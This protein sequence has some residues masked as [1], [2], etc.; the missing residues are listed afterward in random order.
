MSD[1]KLDED[2]IRGLFAATPVYKDAEAFKARVTRGLRLK[3]WLRQGVIVLAGVI[4]G[5]YALAQFVR[6]PNW[7]FGEKVLSSSKMAR[8]ETDQTFRAG[9]EFF[10]VIGKNAVNLFYSSLHYLGIMQ[11]PVFFWVSFSLCLACLALY[12]AYSQE[13]TI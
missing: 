1:M 12:Y 5:L 10:D 8:V 11:T 4:G 3:L 7:T 9:V 13:E 2:D 6:V